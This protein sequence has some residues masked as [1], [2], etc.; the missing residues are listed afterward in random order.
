MT[1]LQRLAAVNYSVA[2]IPLIVVD[3]HDGSILAKSGWRD[4]C[5]E[6]HQNHPVTLQR[7]LECNA[8]V[9]ANLKHQDFENYKCRNGLWHIALPV[10]VDR[11]HMATIFLS[12][13]FYE[14][15]RPSREFFDQQAREFGYD[16][17]KYMEMID[18]CNAFIADSP[19]SASSI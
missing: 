19:L 6:Y 17:P 18:F 3:A 5:T 2:G 4:I 7:C 11:R 12:P 15:D 8:S 13:F 10:R 14:H 9:N 1:D 16:I